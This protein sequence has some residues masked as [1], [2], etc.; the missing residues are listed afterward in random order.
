MHAIGGEILKARKKETAMKEGYKL[1]KRF[2]LRNTDPYENPKGTYHGWFKYYDRTFDSI[3]EAYK[4]FD[5][6]GSYHDG[7]VKIRVKKNKTKYFAKY[8]VHC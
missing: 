7:V 8:E 4:F 2:A 5:D 3:E 6:L 1:A